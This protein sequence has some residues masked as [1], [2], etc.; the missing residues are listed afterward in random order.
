MTVFVVAGH[1]ALST[2][3]LEQR[4]QHLAEIRL[5][6]SDQNTGGFDSARAQWQEKIDSLDRKLGSRN[7]PEQPEV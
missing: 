5:V 1:A 2:S 4:A 7:L 6:V 3:S